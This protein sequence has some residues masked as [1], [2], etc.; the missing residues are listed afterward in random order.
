M[1]PEP[2]R[3]VDVSPMCDAICAALD[4]VDS[5]TVDGPLAVVPTDKLQRLKMSIHSV[6]Q[7]ALPAPGDRV[8]SN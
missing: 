8:C 3:S 7:E 1:D 2:A 6:L 4:L 5:A